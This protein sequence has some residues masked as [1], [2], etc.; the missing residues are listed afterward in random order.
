M[1]RTLPLIAM[2]A[3]SLS[4]IAI[5]APATT[6][7]VAVIRYQPM[8]AA[9]SPGRAVILGGRALTSAEIFNLKS[10][11]FLPL[12]AEMTGPRYGGVATSLPNGNVLVAGGERNDTAEIFSS[13]THRFSLLPNKMTFPRGAPSASA[14]ADGRVL[15]VGGFDEKT[16]DSLRIEESAEVFDPR[17]GRFSVV[18]ANLTEP[19]WGSASALLPNGNVLVVG[20]RN[21]QHA[22]RAEQ[23]AEIF[24]PES[25]RF[26]RLSAKMVMRRASPIAVPLSDGRILIASGHQGGR[27]WQPESVG[28]SAEVFSPKTNRFAVLH[29]TLRDP[30]VMGATAVALPDGVLIVGGA[31]SGE[32]LFGR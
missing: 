29:Q 31:A 5:A 8:G 32:I 6:G 13:E 27:G 9:L 3:G 2:F 11:T 26:T 7:P 22:K 14:L 21:G 16:R 25:E 17:T 15:I 19:R 12:T 4:A 1:R 20:G 23:T 30:H 28:V 24:H 18:R 10:R